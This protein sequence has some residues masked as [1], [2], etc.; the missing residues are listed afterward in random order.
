VKVKLRGALFH[1][2]TCR[3][4]YSNPF[5]HVCVSRMGR[6]A[7]RTKL[8]PSLS[9]RCPKCRKPLGNPLTHTCTTRT[10]FKRRAAKAKKD[11]AAAKRKARPA[12]RYEACRDEDCKRV[13]CAAWR[14]GRREGYRDGFEDGYDGGYSEGYIAGVQGCP[15]GHI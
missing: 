9:A 8:K 3:K 13:P 1:C 11:A 6:A 12:H 2:G 5:G 14:D 7:G 15:R 4:D 10:D